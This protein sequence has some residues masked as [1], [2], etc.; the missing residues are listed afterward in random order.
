MAVPTTI[1]LDLVRT[2]IMAEELGWAKKTLDNRRS[3]GEGPPYVRVGRSV[4]Y[5]RQ[6]VAE[7]LASQQ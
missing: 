4:R 1:A 2:E 5:S 6:A 3:R 7:W